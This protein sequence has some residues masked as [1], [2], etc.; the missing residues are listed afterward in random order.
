MNCPL[1]TY[2]LTSVPLIGFLSE[3]FRALL[4]W[5]TKYLFGTNYV[6]GTGILLWKLFLV[7]TRFCQNI[8]LVAILFSNG[9]I[10]VLFSSYFVVIMLDVSKRQRLSQRLCYMLHFTWIIITDV[11]CFSNYLFSQSCV[12]YI[13]GVIASYHYNFIFNTSVK[14]HKMW[15]PCGHYTVQFL[16]ANYII[17]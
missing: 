13:I 14:W 10:V 11:S 4:H 15:P 2:F 16:R 3:M 8:T 6:F 5:W 9:V 17:P 12:V 7:D 1:I